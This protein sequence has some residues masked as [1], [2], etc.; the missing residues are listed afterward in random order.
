MSDKNPQQIRC[1]KCN[2]EIP[3]T[4]LAYFELNTK[5]DT[6]ETI[7]SSCTLIHGLTY[8]KREPSSFFQLQTRS[9]SEAFRK[10]KP[11]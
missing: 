9:N 2:K 10:F 3:Y 11:K 4:E 1:A 8:D 6:F 7:C 5:T